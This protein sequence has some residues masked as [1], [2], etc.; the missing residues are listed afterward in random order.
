M[1]VSLP[2][3]VITLFSAFIFGLL[4]YYLPGFVFTSE[5]ILWAIV[6]I[7]TLLG[8]DVTQMALTVAVELR[9]LISNLRGQKIL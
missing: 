6:T 3:Y 1:K 8:I 2:I 5:Q 7:L 9:S 4:S